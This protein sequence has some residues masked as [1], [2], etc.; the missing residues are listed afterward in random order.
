MKKTLLLVCCV[1]MLTGCAS[2]GWI[3]AKKMNRLSIGAARADVITMLGEPH[4]REARQGEETLWYLEDQ[5]A[6][7]TSPI[8]CESLV[9]KWIHLVEGKQL[10]GDRCPRQ[11]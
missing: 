3:E 1:A 5:E 10:L 11:L 4:S 6:M 8:T 2:D 7:S 9:A